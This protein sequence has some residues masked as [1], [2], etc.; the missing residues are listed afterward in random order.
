ME[1][2]L[3]C[4]KKE[5]VILGAGNV[6]THLAVNLAGK[7][8]ISQIYNH[9]IAGA[10]EL[11]AKTGAEA[12][13]SLHE[14]RRDADLYIISVKD[15]AI[16]LLAEKLKGRGGLWAHTSGSVPMDVL[17]PISDTYGVFYPM[18][19]FSKDV[20]VDMSE[21]PLFIEGSDSASSDELKETAS[22]ITKKVY[23]AD[24]ERRAKL[25]IAAVFA[26]NFT[27]R[28]WDISANILKEIG[29]GFDTMQ[30][31]VEAM[32]TKA[33]A[34][35]PHEG[36]TGPARRNDTKII[37]KHLDMLDGEAK[38]L[39][40]TLSESIIRQYHPDEQNQL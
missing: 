15:D 25:H 36:Q 32:L 20:D 17:S 30:P 27:N 29:L 31:L 40:S 2:T 26:C 35:T 1:G 16:S 21:V 12:T 14:L 13:D 7:A 37:Q 5:I 38:E 4:R 18:Q 6:A 39:Y 28:L 34:V 22:L 10:Q 8:H 24:S 19:T 33:V 11:A 9:N 3:T 23:D